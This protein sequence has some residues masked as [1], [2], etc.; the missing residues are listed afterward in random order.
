MVNY[1]ID[2]ILAAVDFFHG[3]FTNWIITGTLR[4]QY[5]YMMSYSMYKCPK[6]LYKHVVGTLDSYAYNAVVGFV[7]QLGRGSYHMFL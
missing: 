3:L 6:F 7:R 5:H 1:L 4:S 2:L